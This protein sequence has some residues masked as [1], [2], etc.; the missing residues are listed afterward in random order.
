M[1]DCDVFLCLLEKDALNWIY[2]IWSRPKVRNEV[3]FKRWT[4]SDNKGDAN[5]RFVLDSYAI[6][7]PT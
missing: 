2:F 7:Q 1:D 5:I 6:C 4:D 3:T